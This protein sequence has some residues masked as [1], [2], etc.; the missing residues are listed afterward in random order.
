MTIQTI[1]QQILTEYGV[2]IGTIKNNA[3]WCTCGAFVAGALC[4]WIKMKL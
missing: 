3:V 1:E 4:M 2:I